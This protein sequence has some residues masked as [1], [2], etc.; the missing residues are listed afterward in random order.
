MKS[1]TKTLLTTVALFGA[2]FSALNA[3]AAETDSG[4]VQQLQVS[5]GYYPQYVVQPRVITP[6]SRQARLQDREF[7]LQRAAASTDDKPVPIA[8]AARSLE[9]PMMTAAAPSA[10]VR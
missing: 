2:A 6:A 7:E 9:Q 4:F 1:T 3:R 8:Q 10:D 5:D